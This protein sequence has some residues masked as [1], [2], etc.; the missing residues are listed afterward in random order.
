MNGPSML[1]GYNTNGLP[2]HRLT[3]AIDLLADEGFRSVALTLDAGALDPYD[4]PSNLARQVATVRAA[5]D[6]RGLARVVET[7]ARFL[8]NPRMKHD[9]TLMDPDPARRA[10]RVDFL[11]RSVDLA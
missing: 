2:H 3:D 7:G 6:R 1:L 11:I 10:L 4:D 9:P 8:L 5:L